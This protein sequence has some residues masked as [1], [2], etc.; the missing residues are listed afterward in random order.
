[1]TEVREPAPDEVKPLMEEYARNSRP[2]VNRPAPPPRTPVGFDRKEFEGQE[3]HD[4]YLRSIIN[5]SG[6]TAPA[7]LSAEDR[8]A[9]YI[10]QNGGRP[11]TPAQERRIRKAARKDIAKHEAS[12]AMVA[13]LKGVAQAAE[14]FKGTLDAQG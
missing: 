3:A 5:G 9:H 6:G 1:M 8:I 12:Q 2:T 11:L 13:S 4:R 10:E 14:R 7:P